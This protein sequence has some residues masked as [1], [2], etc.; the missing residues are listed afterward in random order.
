MAV[1]IKKGSA[2]DQVPMTPMIDV[3]FNLLIFFLVASKFA[4]VERALKSPQPESSQAKPLVAQVGDTFVDV[5]AQGKYYVEGRW[6]TV[7]ELENLLHLKWVNNPGKASV[8]IRADRNCRWQ[9]VFTVIDLCVKANIRNYR[10]TA[11]PSPGAG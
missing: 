7:R 10:V 8:I 3:V 5:D 4:E 1:K 2:L 11:G 9:A 6:R